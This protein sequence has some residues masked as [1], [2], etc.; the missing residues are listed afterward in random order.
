MRVIGL[1]LL[2]LALLPATAIGAEPPP[3]AVISDSLRYVNRVPDSSMITEGKFDR[4]GNRSVLVTT[5]RFGFKTYDVSDPRNPRLL[6]SYQP[7]QILGENG[8][9]QDEDMEI[10]RRRKLIIGAL[11]PRHDNVDQASC[12]GIGTNPP[13]AQAKTRNPGCKSGFYVI[14]YRNP[15]NM[16]QI[17]DFVELPAGHTATCIDGCNYIWTGGP[18]RRNDLAYLGPVHAR[19]PRR[20]PADLGHR[21]AQSRSPAGLRPADRPVAQRQPHR[22]LPRRER[23][24]ARHRLGERARRHP[25]LRHRGPLARSADEHHPRGGALGPD[26]GGRRRRGRG[27]AQPQTGFMHNSLRPV[28]GSTRADGVRRGNV[29][30]GTEEDFTTPVRRER[31]RGALRHHRLARR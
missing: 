9:W 8:Y 5:G 10:D 19:R 22:L 27:V 25:R 14:S 31:T 3:G 6:D 20:R 23:G 12:P 26:P 18:A 7:A 2:A 4:V 1:V 30:I 17:G 24:R 13:P 16:R 15:R 28:D 29:L 21:P 11:D